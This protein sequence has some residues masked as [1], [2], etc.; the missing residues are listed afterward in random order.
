[1]T[2]NRPVY[3]NLFKI[4]LPT[5]GI[6]S[7]AHRVSGVF[8][9][10]AIP[11]SIY[12]LDLSVTSAQGFEHSMQLLQG[13]VMQLVLLVLVW[14]LVHHFLAG[15]RYLFLDFDIGI[16]K[17]GSNKSAWSVIVTEVCIMAVYV[18][19]VLL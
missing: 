9:F 15:I 6:V 4:R 8:L 5:T 17:A 14:S 7:F 18:W 13:P 12:L 3:L 2:D 19:V 1:L 11:F 10:L 16:D